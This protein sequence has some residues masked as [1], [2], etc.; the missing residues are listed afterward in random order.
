[1]TATEIMK[2]PAITHQTWYSD[3]L[4]LELPVLRAYVSSVE[5]QIADL[6]N[7]REKCEIVEII[8]DAN[9]G[10]FQEIAVAVGLDDMTYNLEAVFDEY[11]PQLQRQSAL[12][13]LYSFLERE[14]GHLCVLCANSDKSMAAVADR[15]R[16]GSEIA[17]FHKY[18]RD[19]AGLQIKA[20]DGNWQEIDHGIRVVRNQIVHNGG[21]RPEIGSKDATKLRDHIRKLNRVDLISTDGDSVVLGIEYLK[22]MLD[23]FDSFFS[24]IDAAIAAK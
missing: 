8:E 7:W 24:Q 12:I 9:E 23:A 18:L 16:D 20:D 4:S 2:I 5:E 3:H 10:Y 22:Y 6:A 13:V 17:S 15:D 19:E 21:R 1:M 11:F 14:L